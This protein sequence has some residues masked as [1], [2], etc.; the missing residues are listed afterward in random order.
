MFTLTRIWNFVFLSAMEKSAG[1]LVYRNNVS[2]LEVFLMHPGGPFWKK[3]DLGAWS[4]PKGEIGED[5]NEETAARREFEE[6]TGIKIREDLVPLKPIKQKSG[7]S[8]IAWAAEQDID[9]SKIKSNMFEL[10]WPPKSGKMQSFPEM[11][12]AAW[13]SV[14]EAK[15]KIISG[16][17]GLLDELVEKLRK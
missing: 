1:I 2:G 14:S 3:K 13:F 12:R 9:E 8:V 6:E 11:D 7:K 15:E 16:Q 17:V 4:I 5:E 10:E